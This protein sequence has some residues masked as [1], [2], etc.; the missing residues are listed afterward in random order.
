MSSSDHGCLPVNP[1]QPLEPPCSLYCGVC[2]LY[3]ATQAGDTKTL[4][5]LARV[6]AR[7]AP[8]LGSLEGSDLLCD[9][10]LSQRR[11][12]TCQSCGIRQ[13]AD[14]RGFTGCHECRDFPCDHI[15]NFPIETGRR[16]MLRAIPYRRQ[17][18][19]AAWIG[20]EVKR[21]R[22]PVCRRKLYRGVRLCPGCRLE[23]DLD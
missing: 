17:E 20:H 13:C 4:A 1:R 16:V 8:E 7:M 6:Y 23:V 3:Q 9:G 22:C 21:Y 5:R 14:N 11:S 2:R 18:G 19:T 12:V 15:H 10:C